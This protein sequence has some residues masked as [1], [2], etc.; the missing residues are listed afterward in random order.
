MG[1]Y[2]LHTNLQNY[3]NLSINYHILLM[4][5]FFFLFFTLSIASSCTSQAPLSGSIALPA[6]SGP[7]T[8]WLVQPQQFSEIA[9]NFS[10]KVLDSAAVQPDGS[11]AFARMPE[12]HE[13]TL[14]E[15][16][17]QP[18]GARYANR[19]QH[20]PSTANYLPFTWENGEKLFVSAKG[21]P[22]QATAT[23]QPLNADNAALLRLR[24]L[25]G[26]AFQQ[27]QA[28]KPADTHDETALLE[29]AAALARFR[30]P[31]MH[32]ADS[33][34]G[35]WPALVATRWVSPN[36][37]FERVAE[38]IA[39]QCARWQ[40]ERPQNAWVASLCQC[41][42]PDKLPVLIGQSVPDFPLPM[43]KGDTTRLNQLL[44]RRLTLLDLWASWC[45][46]CRREN[47]NV[48]VPLWDTYHTHGFQIIGYALDAELSGWQAAIE[49][50]GAGRWPHA[51]HL[52]GDDAPL[53]KQLRLT[54]IPANL[55]L[56]AQGVIVAKN[57]HGEALREFVADYL[58]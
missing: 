36:G 17:L 22:F 29:E 40:A 51:S 11:F 43:S 58:K 27:Y 35:F 20:D 34:K 24:D 10:G 32:F 1:K 12:A 53:M 15:L 45:A 9:A 56:D 5:P 55:L 25:R 47:R 14:F 30:Q 33:C 28:A 23:L 6:G 21:G 54:T 31:L 8:V 18:R 50:D 26:S 42:Q 52:Q 3:L 7:L 2:G 49:K 41:G 4:R 39:R 44:G 19:L 46:P 57:L 48:L 37:D 38:F 13:A 16:V